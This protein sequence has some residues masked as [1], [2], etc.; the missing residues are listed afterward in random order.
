MK[1]TIVSIVIP[2]FNEKE[3]ISELLRTL[4][5]MTCESNYRFEYIFVDDGSTDG[6]L[7]LFN[8]EKSVR[9]R[10]MYAYRFK[11]NRGK[12]LALAEGF[13]HAQGDYI[14]TL[15]AD[16]QDDPAEIPKLLGKLEEG[17][18]LVVGWRKDRKD[19]PGKIRSS[20]IFNWVVSR[21]SGVNLHDMNCGLKAYRKDVIR[22][23]RLYGELHRFIPVL[24]AKRGLQVCEI[25]VIHHP[26]IHGA[27]KYNGSRVGHAFFDLITILFLTSFSDRPLKIFG[28][29]G[30]TFIIS[31]T[32]IL[33]YLSCLHF[34][35][36]TIG[37]RPLLFFG[38]LLVLF[39]IQLFSTG[40][41]GE[42]VVNIG[43]K[44][45]KINSDEMVEKLI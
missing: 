1:K 14:V 31:G 25:P 32:V 42:L 33:I 5:T 3:N 45:K 44:D 4:D 22:D 23:I 13:R 37:R 41:I 18:D 12:S 36:Q 34:L 43:M 17:N 19:S 7:N 35:G 20:R 24:A 38:I 40:L 9:N 21:L 11:I 28:P 26:R 16:L 15:D 2:T 6:S 39:G 30:L 27:S 29:A 8:A 10:T